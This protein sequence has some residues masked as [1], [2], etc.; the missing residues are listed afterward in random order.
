MTSPNDLTCLADCKAWLGLTSATDDALIGELV[1]AVSQAILADLGRSAILPL[2]CLETLDGGG[3][4]ALS[5][6]SWP[7]TRLLSCTIDGTAVAT[8]VAP[9]RMGVVLDAADS[10]PPGAMQRLSF[11]GGAFPTGIQNIAVAYRAGYEILGEVTVV[12][13]AAPFTLTALQPYGAWRIDTGV[14][15]LGAPYTAVAGLYTF[16]PTDAGASITLSYGY[17]PAALA[18]AALE[19]VAD[20]YTS[21]GR[22]GQSAKT[23][24]GQETASFIVKAMPDVVSRL[25]QPFRRVAR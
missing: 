5:L 11:R 1:T 24:G 12:P 9:G 10:A 21:R 3:E 20:R 7:A 13:S 8:S 18:Q 14:T 16:A 4:R 15:G 17:V 19:W 22:I 25:L 2:T 23:L 6:R